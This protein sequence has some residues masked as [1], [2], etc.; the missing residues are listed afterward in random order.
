MMMTN[1]ESGS[2]DGFIN[3]GPVV[4]WRPDGV[5]VTSNEMF[6]LNDFLNYSVPRHLDGEED[7]LTPHA[8]AYHCGNIGLYGYGFT[9]ADVLGLH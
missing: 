9:E 2:S 7:I 5:P 6:L 3:P 8:W 4:V 1:P